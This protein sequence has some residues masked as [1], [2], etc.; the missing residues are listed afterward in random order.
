MTESKKLLSPQQEKFLSNYKNP[1][2]PLFGNAYRSALD[3]GY[4]EEYAK[5]ILSQMPSWLSENINDGDMLEKAEKALLEAISLEIRDA[6]DKVDPAIARIKADVSKFVAETV[7][8]A[9]YSKRTEH[10][11]KD[12]GAI[13]ISNEVKEAMENA[14]EEVI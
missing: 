9:K 5:T 10:T 7:G 14:L 2:S 11:G 13:V 8:R 1:S 12:G 3:A 6:N 4:G